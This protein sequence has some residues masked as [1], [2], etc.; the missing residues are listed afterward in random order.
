[1]PP[2]ARITD[3]VQHG[4]GLLGMLVGAV[5]GAALVVGTCATGG[6]LGAALVAGAVSG[7]ALAGGKIMNGLAAIFDLPGIPTGS[8]IMQASP[9]VFI[10]KQMACRAQLDGAGCNG[11]IALYH[12][13][14]PTAL[15]AQG[16]A[17]VLINGQPAARI[18]DKLVCGGT[19]KTGESSVII[20]GDTATVLPIHDPEE[21][22]REILGAV[23]IVSAVILTGGAIGAVAAGTLSA[24]AFVAGVGLA[25][26]FGVTSWAAEKYLPPGWN[27]LVSGTIDMVG[28]ATMTKILEGVAEPIYPPT[29][30]VCT[31]AT[32]FVL[33]GTLE[34]RFERYYASSLG[35]SDWLGPNWSCSWGQRVTNTGAGVVRY[36]PGT[37]AAFYLI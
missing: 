23:A 15:V 1:M 8:I 10:G 6:L 27:Q 28:L 31:M 26:A 19:I 18:G 14:M 9:N 16:S 34:L 17:S 13:P 24:G 29:G 22:L 30:E 7:G 21:E 5:V 20:G 35:E 25:G 3:G 33:P 36:F 4:L 11:V 12:W 37:D 2:A 32:D